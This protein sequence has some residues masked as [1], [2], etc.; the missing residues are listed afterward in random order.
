MEFRKMVTITLYTRQQKR[1]WCIEQSFG[2]CGRDRGWNDLGEWHWNTYNIIYG[3]SCQS[4]FDARY[5]MLGAGALGRPRGMVRGGRREE[6]SGWG[7]HVYLWRNHFDEWQ[8][9]YNIV[10]FKNKIKLKK[11]KF[12]KA[13]W[14]QPV[15]QN[16]SQS[17]HGTGR[18][19]NSNQLEG[20]G[21]GNP[22]QCSCLENPRDGGAWWAAV[23][24]VA[25]SWTP[26]K[27]LSSSSSSSSRGKNL[28]EH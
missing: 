21:N 23:Y 20:E 16:Y 5:W 2:L 25:Q 10:K 27:R 11:K 6:G 7:T 13:S 15:P 9:Q 4:R 14:E 19:V 22:L 1:H 26:L 17:S 28:V 3:M 18:H 8:N 24:G 12:N